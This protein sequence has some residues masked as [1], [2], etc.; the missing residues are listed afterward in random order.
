[1]PRAVPLGGLGSKGDVVGEVAMSAVAEVVLVFGP[2][3]PS[4]IGVGLRA[5]RWKRR[6]GG[7]AV[8]RRRR[9]ILESHDLLY[10]WLGGL[11]KD[12]GIFHFVMLM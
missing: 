9:K 4:A 7:G 6:S 10:P 2:H 1:M 11:L 3:P 12:H 8:A 5:F